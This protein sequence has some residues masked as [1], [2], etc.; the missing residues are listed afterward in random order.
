MRKLRFSLLAAI[1]CLTFITFRYIYILRVYNF[2]P[3]HSYIERIPVDDF[4]LK[5]LQAGMSLSKSNSLVIY[6]IHGRDAEHSFALRR[7][8]YGD[9]SLS[10][11]SNPN[12]EDGD[13]SKRNPRTANI[14]IVIARQTERAIECL[15]SRNLLPHDPDLNRKLEE[16]GSY[17][18]FYRTDDATVAGIAHKSK[19]HSNFDAYEFEGILKEFKTIVFGNS[20][21]ANLALTALDIQTARIIQKPDNKE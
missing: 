4:L 9:T 1:V 16:Y 6:E 19:F 8:Q 10:V 11:Q 5:E 7:Q 18:M 15:L 3:S 12:D 20:D 13:G 2:R 17:W 14:P 21:E